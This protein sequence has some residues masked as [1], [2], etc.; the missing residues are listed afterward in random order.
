VEKAKTKTTRRLS[1]GMD[2]AGLGERIKLERI[3][4]NLSLNELANR[5][6]V[7]VSMLSEVER[8]AKVPSILVLDHIATGLNITISRLLG[9]E[10]LDRVIV[11]R[12]TEQKVAVDPTGWERR[13]LSPVLKGVEFEF[14]QTTLGPKVDAGVYLPHPPASREY[15]VVTEG[16]LLLTLDNRPYLLDK[17][18]SIYYAAD[19]LHGF[20][21]PTEEQCRYFLV[22]DLAASATSN[23][24]TEG[25]H[26][27]AN[28]E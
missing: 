28:L 25:Y 13:I 8:G 6:G 2:I 17:G 21:N 7:S 15:L 24:N 27:R 3:A 16:Q 12:Q 1:T 4:R 14:M 5:T 11:L 19:C 18:D 26:I 23:S 22:M 9:E 20:A 10:Q